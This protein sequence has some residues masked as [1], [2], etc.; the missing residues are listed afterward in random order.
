MEDLEFGWPSADAGDARD[1]GTDE[2]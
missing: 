1:A 2:Q